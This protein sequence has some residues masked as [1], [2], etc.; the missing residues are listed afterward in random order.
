MS[1]DLYDGVPLE[2]LP[3]D[4]VYVP[5]PTHLRRSLRY[6]GAV[7]IAPEHA[8]QAALDPRRLVA[9]DRRIANEGGDPDRGPL[10]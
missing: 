10:A 3:I 6:P 8:V 9:R 7:D 2:R 1:D 5:D 4:V